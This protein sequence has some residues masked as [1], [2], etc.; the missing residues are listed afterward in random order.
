MGACG[1]KVSGSDTPADAK[2]RNPVEIY[3]S[4]D[5]SDSADGSERSPYRTLEGARDAIRELRRQGVDLSAGVTVK[6]AGGLYP[7]ADTLCFTKEDSGTAEAPIHYQAMPGAVPSLCAGIR[8][9]A[10]DFGPVDDASVRDAFIDQEAARKILVADLSRFGIR[11]LG[12]LSRT[13]F[14]RAQELRKSPPSEFF[15]DGQPQTLARWPNE[16]ESV[17]MGEILDPG[18][19]AFDVSMLNRFAFNSKDN[20]ALSDLLGEQ[21]GAKAL[22]EALAKIPSAKGKTYP[23]YFPYAASTAARGASDIHERGGAFRFDYER[24]LKWR[25][26][27]DIWIA[28]VFG[29]SWEYSYNKVAKIDDAQRTITLRYGEMSGLNKNWFKDFHHYENVLEEIDRPGEYYLD[30]KNHKLYFLPPDGLFDGGRLPDLLI[31]VLDKPVLTTDGASHVIFSGFELSGGRADAVRISRG[32]GVV[33]EDCLI[34]SFAGSG[35]TLERTVDSGL[36][37]CEIRQVGSAGVI[38]GGGDWPT[39][40]P[41]NNFV[42][43]CL[44]HDFAYREKAWKP[45]VMLNS[46]SVGNTV[47]G[48]RIY[49]APHSGIIIKGNDHLIQGNEIYGLCRDILDAGA[50]YMNGQ[51]DPMDRGVRILE[52]Y[53][54]DIRPEQAH[55]IVGIYLDC[56][57]FDVEVRNNV[58]SRVSRAITMKGHYLDVEDNLIVDAREAAWGALC[59]S[60]WPKEWKA[61]F[62]QYP[63]ASSPHGKKYPELA[64]FWKDI[65]TYGRACGPLNLFAGNT[66]FDPYN[67]LTTAS[68]ADGRANDYGKG[69]DGVVVIPTLDDNEVIHTNPG[70]VDWEKGNFYFTG[71]DAA[72]RERLAFL[73]RIFDERGHFLPSRNAGVR[74][75]SKRAIRNEP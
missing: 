30:R 68:G 5:G 69:G 16:G 54:H 61:L 59:D 15:V 37:Y 11:S 53:I 73:N 29:F 42:S 66:L 20:Q 55:G 41:G 3:V 21:I 35:V 52:N 60:L 46:K 24:P 40:T 22:N 67:S 45:A 10:S 2:E 39:L 47:I 6:V 13:G 63:I 7:Q 8:L 17:R 4:P 38:L 14:S 70:F 58:V 26:S 34:H 32:Q 50:I 75:F 12:E 33:L 28:G 51:R 9:S 31:S 48:N 43:N 57:T 27:N 71:K 18:P 56:M 23:E 49:D 74:E 65:E 25:Q 72:M 64:H 19:I 44:L 36:R 1:E 62:D